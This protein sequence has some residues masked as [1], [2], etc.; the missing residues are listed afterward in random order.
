MF[1]KNSAEAFEERS[2]EEI[3]VAMMCILLSLTVTE[4][5][6]CARL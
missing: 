1:N 6:T 4:K 2:S 3:R 5:R